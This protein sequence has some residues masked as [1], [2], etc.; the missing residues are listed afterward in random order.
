MSLAKRSAGAALWNSA[1]SVTRIVL[2]FGIGVLLARLIG[3]QEFGLVAIAVLMVSIGQLFVDFGFNAAIVQTKDLRETDITSLGTLQI[4]ISAAMSAMAFAGA[5]PI[6]AFFHQPAA[7]PIIRWMGLMLL[8]RGIGQNAV[9]LLNRD[10]R[11]RA[12]Q[13]GIMAGYVIG[14]VFVAVPLAFLGFGAW[15]LVAGQLV[16]AGLSS[17]IAI[18]QVGHFHPLSLRGLRREMLN[19]GRLVISANLGSWSLSNLDSVL[20]GHVAGSTSL[21]FYNRSMMLAI[22]P[23]QAILSGLQGVLF[24]A[25]SRAQDNPDGCRRALYTCM[26]IMVLIAAPLLFAVAAVSHTVLQALYGAKWIAAA[27]LLAPLCVAS[28][29]NGVL[30]F[31]G[32]VIMGLGRIER[33]TRAQWLAVVIMVPCV[34]AAARVSAVAVAWAI[35]ALYLVRFALLWR[36]LDSVL[37]LDVR[38]IA[39]ATVPGAM[40]GVMA[41]AGTALGDRS[42]ADW[43]IAARLALEVATGGAGA[44]AGLVM[45]HR[46]LLRGEVGRMLLDMGPLPAS[47]RAWL[48]RRAG[49]R[50]GA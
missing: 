24:A 28:V 13:I 21:A 9:A 43:G 2:Q 3:P 37:A 40:I 20:V 16:Q 14:Y 34:Y 8:L 30:G 35:V 12:V 11:F 10:L 48:A 50:G 18:V 15:S 32:P 22:A 47:L 6:A 44:L 33:E 27:P 26:E 7:V 49:G 45:V 29:I 46:Y 4:V 38:S 36:A 1:G 23:T 25:A 17:V 5:G 39:R 41:A 42:A 19:F 31:F